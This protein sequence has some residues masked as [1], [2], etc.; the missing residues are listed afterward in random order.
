MLRLL[1]IFALLASWQQTAAAQTTL[2]SPPS[3][4]AF[5]LYM[6][7]A[8]I[9]RNDD[10][11]NLMSP[12]SSNLIYPDYPPITDQWLQMEKQDYDAHAQVRELV[13]QASL[14]DRAAWP[15]FDP[16]HVDLSYLNETRNLANEIADSVLYQS[17]VL[18]DQPAAFGSAGDLLH[19]SDLLRNQPGELLIR[20]LVA[21]GIEAADDSRL[22]VIISGLS[23]T[24]SPNNTQALPLPTATQWITRLLDQ[25]DPQSELDQAMKGE[26]AGNTTNPILKPTLLRILETIRRV[27]TERD[28]VAMSLA[29]HVYQYQ[30]HRWPQNLDELK[31]QLPRLPLDPWG[32]GKQTLG[33][34]L[35]KAGLPD[36]SDRPLVYSR[37][38]VKAA[39]FFR[40]DQPIYSYTP[41]DG[42]QFRDV[43]NWSPPPGLPSEPTTQPLQINSAIP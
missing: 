17:L 8:K 13:R 27:H 41:S 3:D 12:A 28:L 30:H 42:G 34:A 23:I 6:Q 24:E 10:N 19:L 16:Q 43:A 36:G 9:L 40:V 7:A 37:C 20:L 18:N 33:Y 4:D 15:P 38:G 5:S 14:L 21:E 29:A 22:M 2:T 39:L 32:D 26:L 35:I 25:P 31:T 11:R 1:L